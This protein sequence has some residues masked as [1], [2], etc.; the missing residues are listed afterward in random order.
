MKNEKSKDEHI[1]EINLSNKKTKFDLIV[2]TIRNSLFNVLY[3]LLQ[4]E[5]E[6]WKNEVFPSVIELLQILNFSISPD[7]CII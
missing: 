4:Q 6:G 3:L 5:D 2:E 7:V 1:I